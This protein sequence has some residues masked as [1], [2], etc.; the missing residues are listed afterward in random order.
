M[1]AE[2]DVPLHRILYVLATR[3]RIRPR[4]IAGNARLFDNAA[5]AQVR[6]ELD[7]IDD[8]R[9]GGAAL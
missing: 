6:H 2:L 4:A 5:I 9:G 3:R 1:A 8:R 7:V